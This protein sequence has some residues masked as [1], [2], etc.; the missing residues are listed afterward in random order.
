[1]EM[2]SNPKKLLVT[3]MAFLP[4]WIS[5]HI[6]SAEIVCTP[7]VSEEDISQ[8]VKGFDGLLFMQTVSHYRITRKIIESA[9]KLKFVQTGGVGYDPIDVDAATD[10]G[11][12]VMNVP[13]A[14]TVSVAEHAIA[15]ILAC[16]KNII[17]M[18]NTVLEG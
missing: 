14:T 16:A 2:K 10:H 17:K 18:H 7:D 15:L 4:E 8:K 13:H 9:D 6:K 5:Q 12:I 3:G 1:M 11:V